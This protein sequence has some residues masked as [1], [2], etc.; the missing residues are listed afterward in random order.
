MLIHRIKVYVCI[1]HKFEK[2]ITHLFLI[3]STSFIP[4]VYIPLAYILIISI[5]IAVAVEIENHEKRLVK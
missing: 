5:S 2:A 3:N 4:P 1:Q